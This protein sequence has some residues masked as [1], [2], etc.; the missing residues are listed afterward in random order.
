MIQAHYK[1][2]HG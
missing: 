2:V 1:A